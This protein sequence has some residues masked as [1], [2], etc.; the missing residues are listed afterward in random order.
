MRITQYTDYGLR[1]LIYLGLHR[2]EITPMPTIANHYGIS[3]NHLMK[4]TQ[5]LT[6]LGYVESTRGRTGGLRLAKDPADI[7][8]GQVV[9]EMEPMEIVDCFSAE[10]R[11]VIEPGCHLKGILGRALRAFLKELEQHTLA[12]LV[13]N[14]DEL[15]L[16]FSSSPSSVHS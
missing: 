2:E 15:T 12:E 5:Q 7:N 6:K 13:E 9:R 16:L 3:S 4:V 11:C 10:G 1:V 14:K 8:I